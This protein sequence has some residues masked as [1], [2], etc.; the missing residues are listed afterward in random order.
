MVIFG[1]EVQGLI[2]MVIS[3]ALQSAAQDLERQRA[4]DSLRKGLERRPEK[5]ELVE[6][7]FSLFSPHPFPFS[8][9]LPWSL[10][11]PFCFVRER[12]RKLMNT[13]YEGNILPDSTAAPALQGQQREL[14]K[15][16]RANSLEQKLQQRPKPEE[17]VKEGILEEGENPTV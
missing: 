4:T 7:M 8:F 14:A 3:R 6:R 17:L 5:E 16:M 12:R 2:C 11:Y 9:P 1:F 10:G 15:H 13:L